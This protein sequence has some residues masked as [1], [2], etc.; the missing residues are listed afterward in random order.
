MVIY[1]FHPLPWEA[2]L[3]GEALPR[4]DPGTSN[5]CEAQLTLFIPYSQNNLL[6]RQTLRLV[7]GD[8][9]TQHQRELLAAP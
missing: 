4:L 2:V 5:I 7:N 6:Q 1:L 3:K 9:P 8:G